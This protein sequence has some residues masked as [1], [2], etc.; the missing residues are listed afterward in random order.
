MAA[1]SALARI[2]EAALRLYA[3]RGSRAITVSE[4]AETAG[5]SRGTIY[6]NVEHIDALYETVA[7]GLVHEMHL[8][9]SAALFDTAD[10]AR[11]VATGVRMFLRRAHEEPQWGRFLVRF[12]AH[13]DNLR[14]LMNEPPLLDIANGI[15]TGRFKPGSL[16]PE[17][18]V[19]ALV[20]AT[21]GAIHTVIAGRQT[22]REAGT[23]T[24]TLMLRA[25]GLDAEEA[26][27]IAREEL[28]APPRNKRSNT[29]RRMETP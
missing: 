5:V 10:P 23:A 2:Q 18:I 21:F 27:R 26:A 17:S 6:N 11:R 1:P 25:L 14:L 3:E 24:A 4:L 7:A 29:R 20:G 8:T 12:A 15:E 19:S 28:P 13:D 16:T 9:V 22:W